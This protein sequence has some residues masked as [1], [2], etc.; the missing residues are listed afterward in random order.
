MSIYRKLLKSSSSVLLSQIIS[1]ASSLLVGIIFARVLG[2]EGKGALKLLILVP[3]M[4][5]GFGTMGIEI[6]NI[7][8]IGQKKY[9]IQLL[10]GNTI[11]VTIVMSVIIMIL[12]PIFIP[13][14]FSVLKVDV[15]YYLKLLTYF[16]VPLGLLG[17]FL[18]SFLLGLQ[19]IVIRSIIDIIRS[20]SLLL[21]III[22]I[23]VFH[24]GLHSILI[25]NIFISLLPV[26]LMFLVLKDVVKIFPSY[27]K[28]AFKS[29][30]CFG[31]KGYVGNVTHYFNIRLDL[32]L[33]AF[34]LGP[35]EVGIYSVA[36]GLGE[37]IWYIPSA[38]STVMFPAIAN[39]TMGASKVLAINTVQKLFIPFIII[40][41][42]IAVFGKFFIHFLYGEQFITAYPAL[43][44]LL[45]GILIM[46]ICGPFWDY[47]TGIGKIE[48]NLLTAP[49][50]L[51]VTVALDIILI[52]KF[53]IVG[54]AI[55]SSCA[56]I[57]ATLVII[58]LY[59]KFSHS[60]ITDLGKSNSS[61]ND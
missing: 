34:F 23:F 17:T 3:S 36:V 20:V 50:S 29:V 54:A 43:V 55:A 8:F 24:A 1:F 22:C 41:L 16:I 6:A 30:F 26:G 19:R 40:G 27:D 4:I 32:F 53:G 7:Y 49:L 18:S 60:S 33:V 14:F 9:D 46:G 59:L 58:Y 42:G 52:P 48:Y 47:I 35:K 56:Y 28:E 51:G 38:I 12:Y 2:P 5:V 25:I 13:H 44:L 61:T 15:P 45:P 21:F 39:S 31:I 57:V 11:V 37:L 10:M